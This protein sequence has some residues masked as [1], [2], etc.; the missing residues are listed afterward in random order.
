MAE[1][2]TNLNESNPS[3]QKDPSDKPETKDEKAWFTESV[4][5]I[6]PVAR[7]LL[8]HYSKIAPDEVIPHVVALVRLSFST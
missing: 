4:T 6:P 8:E 2:E 3:S 5:S 7:E 1:P